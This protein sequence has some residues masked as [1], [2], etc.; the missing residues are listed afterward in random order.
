M[1]EVPCFLVTLINFNG[2]GAADPRGGTMRA[3]HL[4]YHFFTT[5]AADE[6]TWHSQA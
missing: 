6:Q 5:S 4:P 2:G 1:H 3:P